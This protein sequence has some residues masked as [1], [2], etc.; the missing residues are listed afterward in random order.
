M[1]LFAKSLL[2]YLDEVLWYFKS[3]GHKSSSSTYSNIDLAS[4]IDLVSILSMKIYI[5]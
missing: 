1:K 4:N 5:Y 3:N 2:E